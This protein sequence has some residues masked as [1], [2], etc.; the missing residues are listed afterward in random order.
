MSKK[1]ATYYL[2]CMALLAATA[3]C[4]A[5]TADETPPEGE[6]P[7]P[8]AMSGETAKAEL[9][10]A[11][12]QARTGKRMTASNVQGGE[13]ASFLGMQ[14]IR[15]IPLAT[16]Y[17]GEIGNASE[18]YLSYMISLDDIDDT[19]GEDWTTG[20]TTNGH[21][22][23]RKIYTD[24]NIPTGTNTFLFYGQA[25]YD[26]YSTDAD[27]WFAQ[28]ALE[29]SLD[30]G[31]ITTAA[32]IGF[33]LKQILTA[34]LETPKNALLAQLNQ[35]MGVNSWSG[36]DDASTDRD[37]QTLAVL[38]ANMQEL[39]AGSAEAVR[40]TLESLYNAVSPIAEAQAGGEPQSIAQAIQTAITG[41]SAL[42]QASD[43]DG[44]GT[45]ELEWAV[46]DEAIT[47]FPAAQHLPE[48]A[49]QLAW[50]DTE[51]CFYYVEDDTETGG[52]GITVGGTDKVKLNSL[53]YP[54]S[55]AYYISTAAKT[56]D[57]PTA[58]F[59]A[60]GSWT[61]IGNWSGWEGAVQP[62]TRLVALEKN[63]QYGVA[64]LATTVK[65]ANNNVDDSEGNSVVVGS[66]RFT[67]D[68]ILVGGQ[69]TKLGY[70]LLPATGTGAAEFTQTVYDN[71]VADNT[72]VTTAETNANYT[73]LLDNKGA[74]GND[75]E[76]DKVNFALEMT[77]NGDA[78][79]GVDGGLIAK[80][81][82]FYLVGTLNKA[83]SGGNASSPAPSGVDH[84]FIQDYKTTATVTISSL[85]NAYVTI[86]DLRATNLQLGLSVDLEWQKGYTFN[87]GID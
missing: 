2:Y 84:I 65:F 22:A 28:G 57:D 52:D 51:D 70:N 64:Q 44:D 10:I 38:Y 20:T 68:G 74:G 53:T 49:V 54:A 29:T 42:F 4:N 86:P 18:C 32:D 72:Y 78:F 36:T 23:G 13:N 19:G 83:A 25:K 60:A 81:M 47:R 80:G 63:I 48:G 87:V 61:N 85:K 37:E 39:R 27:K 62:T 77:N 17:D 75:A 56:N 11:I 15:L 71:A 69:P 55:L 34:D 31:D 67:L 46:T 43:T 21:D 7:A 58:S 73:L 50:N 1:K 14:D 3:A 79:Y 59:P 76:A 5:C 30:D 6:T 82:K 12:P 16:A 40:L 45:Y 66:D 35:V 24:V 33:N 41:Q 9:A 26:S 8:P